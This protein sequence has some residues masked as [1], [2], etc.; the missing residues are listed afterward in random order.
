ME[1]ARV[2]ALRG[3]TVTLCEKA[4]RL[5]GT[6]LFA[7]LVYEANGKLV[8]HWVQIDQ[9]AMLTQLGHMPAPG[10]APA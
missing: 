4:E 9:M 6:A 8:E 1:A 3:H 7:A 2:A 10:Q 5:G